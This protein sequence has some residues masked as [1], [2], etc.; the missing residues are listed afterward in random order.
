MMESP[1][2][3]KTAHDYY[4]EA[5]WDAWKLY[6]RLKGEQY[7]SSLQKVKGE[8]VD[9]RKEVL[10]DGV[11]DGIVFPM[12]SAL[13]RFVAVHRGRWQLR[14]PGKFP[15]NTLFA[16]AELLFKNT[17]HHNPQS[18]GKDTDCYIA[19]DGAMD[20]YFAATRE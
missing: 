16:Q 12:M 5:S 15:W 18:M 9:G 4:L 11:P 10:P 13:S 3:W 14:I 2:S 7:F 8:V 19:L 6:D 17:A 1:S 20:M